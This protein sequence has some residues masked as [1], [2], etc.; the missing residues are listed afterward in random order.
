MTEQQRAALDKAYEVKTTN[1]RFRRELAAMTGPQARCYVSDWLVNF[2]PADDTPLGAMTVALLLRA[3]PG[4]GKI[5]ANDMMRY[6]RISGNKRMRDTT[7]EQRKRLAERIL[8]SES[9][10]AAMA[11]RHQTATD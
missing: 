1:G 4:I 8:R 11:A 2:S 9:V 7:A 5:R 3:V 10:K 6:A